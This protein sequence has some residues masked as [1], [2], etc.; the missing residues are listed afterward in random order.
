MTS[1]GK[2]RCSDENRNN[3]ALI[4]QALEN[5]ENGTLGSRSTLRPCFIVQ[6]PRITAL[7]ELRHDMIGHGVAFVLAEAL[8][9]TPDDLGGTAQG[10]GD[11]VAKDVPSGHG[12]HE[13]TKGT[14]QAR[15]QSLQR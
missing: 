11:A 2:K 7:L 10:K 3:G 15:G 6:A 9:E 14:E 12:D 5:G 4:P 13:N 8:P 1:A